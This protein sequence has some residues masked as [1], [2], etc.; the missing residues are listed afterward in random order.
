MLRRMFTG[1]LAAAPVALSQKQQYNPAPAIIPAPQSQ[2]L[3]YGE[4]LRS[5]KE[6]ANW[7][8][9]SKQRRA[10]ER[11]RHAHYER[12]NTGVSDENIKALRSVSAQHKVRMQVAFDERQL[13]ESYSLLDALADKLGVLEF[14]KGSEPRPRYS[15]DDWL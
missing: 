13:R 11:V 5:V 4:T 15:D 8:L 7:A 2:P 9:F 6:P 14:W 3:G 10:I 1:G 12:R